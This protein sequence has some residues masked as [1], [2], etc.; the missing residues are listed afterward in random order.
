MLKFGI[1]GYDHPHILRYAPTIAG[2]KDVQITSIAAIGTNKD[3]AKRDAAKFKSAYY[4]NLDEMLSSEELD[5]IYIGTE[6]SR[7]LEVVKEI[8]PKGIHILCDKPIATNLKEADEIISLAVSNKIKLMVPFNPPYQLGVIR[9]KEMIKSGEFGEIYHLSA[10]KYGKI[11]IVIKGIDTSWFLDREKAGFGGLA[12]IGIHAVYGI[13]WLAGKP[14]KK[15]YAK[16]ERKIHKEIPVDDI[17]TV[18]IE[19]DGGVIGTI[20]AGWANP[21]GFP[22][23]L[24]A[25]FEVLGSKKAMNVSKP[26]HD[27]KIFDQEKTEYVNWWRV[28]IDRLINEFVMSIIEDREPAITGRDARAALEIIVAAYKSSETGEEINLPLLS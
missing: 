23:H 16:I 6:P 22:T 5:A 9:M 4:E 14:A 28:D 8:A 7:H 24:D 26:Y 10:T 2:H 18:F 21:T 17:G 15:V 3:I 20:C 27:F 12:D 25:T 1:I 19:F 11:P 13:M